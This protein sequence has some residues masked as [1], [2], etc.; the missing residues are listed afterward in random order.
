MS[1]QP[2]NHEN[3]AV[4]V[5]VE[6]LKKSFGRHEVLHGISLTAEPGEILCVIGPSGCGKSVLLRHIIGLEKPDAGRV[7]IEGLDASSEEAKERFRMAMVFQSS[8]LFNSMSVVENVA[9][10][11]RENRVHKNEG[12]ILKAVADK[13][14]LLSLEGSEHKVPS[15]LS[16]GMKKRVAIA[17]AL[18]MNPNLILYDEPTAE[19][20]PIMSANIGGI[21]R[22]LNKQVEVT[23]IV[24]THDREL[25]F[26][27]G[28]RIS[29]MKDG[30]IVATGTPREIRANSDPVVQ[31]FLNAKINGTGEKQHA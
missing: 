25:A 28:D 24:V 22:D 4:R 13:L 14:V 23:S 7:M 30:N 1:D 29:M 27:I 18:V 6:G 19:L 10:Y 15:E 16:G 31:E 26:A 5:K 12:Q 17:R 2:T 20:D 9:L 8:A 21:I 11:L 3:R